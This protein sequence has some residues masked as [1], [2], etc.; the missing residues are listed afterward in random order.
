MDDRRRSSRRAGTGRA[1]TTLAELV[2]SPPEHNRFYRNR[3]DGTFEDATAASGLAGTGWSGDVGGL[4]RGRGRRPR[5][6]RV[7][8]VRAEHALRE[9]REGTVHRRDGASAPAGRRGAPSA[10]RPSTTPATG[11]STSSSSTCTPTCGW[12]RPTTRR[13][14]RRP[15]V[16]ARCTARRASRPSWAPR[17]GS[18]SSST[19]SCSGTRST[20]RARP[21]TFAEFSADAGVETLWPWGIA[22]ADFDADGFEDA[23][24]PSGMGYPYRYWR[25]PLLMNRGN[26]TF[27]DASAAA[28]LD[29]LPGGTLQARADRRE[30]RGAQRALRGHRRLRRRRPPR[31]RGQHVQRPRD[32]VPQPLADARLGRVPAASGAAS[33]ATRSARSSA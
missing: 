15:E 27:A 19:G 30:A 9:R 11:G 3:G 26:G 20:A 22:V 2:E 10:P 31:P 12:T 1:A 25:S 13:R 17:R 33:T 5:P 32:A 6:L 23:F 28:G 7:Q 4:R 21:A 14:R 16:P 8:H 24:V 18:G 29:P